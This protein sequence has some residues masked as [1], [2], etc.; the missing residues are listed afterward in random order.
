MV[1]SDYSFCCKSVYDT[2]DMWEALMRIKFMADCI[3]LS[4]LKMNARIFVNQKIEAGLDAA[5]GPIVMFELDRFYR[6]C[7][8]KFRSY[9]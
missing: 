7:N 1:I 2:N 4:K 6:R 8:H 3:P 5:D 9:P